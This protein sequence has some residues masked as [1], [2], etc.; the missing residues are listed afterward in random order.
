MGRLSVGS[1]GVMSVGAPG[2]REGKEG[3]TGNRHSVGSGDGGGGVK[4]C[5]CLSVAPE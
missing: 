1:W 3:R 2:W 5:P 4:R